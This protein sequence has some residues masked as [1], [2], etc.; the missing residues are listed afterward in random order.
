MRRKGWAVAA[1]AILLIVGALGIAWLNPID[2]FIIP[3]AG[4]GIP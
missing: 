2:P 1:I 4:R 3:S